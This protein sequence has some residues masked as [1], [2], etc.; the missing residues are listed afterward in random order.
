MVVEQAAAE[1][2]ERK[3]REMMVAHENLQLT[4]IN[5]IDNL[6]KLVPDKMVEEAYAHIYVKACNKILDPEYVS[7]HYD[8][9][10]LFGNMYVRKLGGMKYLKARCEATG[11]PFLN[12]L[13][14]VCDEAAKKVV[15]KK[16]EELVKAIS[17][18]DAE[19]IVRNAISDKDK[20]DLLD[21]IDDLGADQ[22]AELVK[23]KVVDVVRDEQIRERDEREQR[24]VLKNDLIS[25]D[26]LGDDGEDA[27]D[28]ADESTKKKGKKKKEDDDAE[29]DDLGDEDTDLGE[30]ESD[31]DKKSDKKKSKKKDKEDDES[32]DDDDKKK[33]DS[34]DDDKDSDNEDEDDDDKKSKKKKKDKEETKESLYPHSKWNPMTEQFEFI[35]TKNPGSF[36]YA[37]N[38]AIYQDMVKSLAATEG[39]SFTKDVSKRNS[40]LAMEAADSPLNISTFADYML[41]NQSG[42]R[43][44]ELAAVHDPSVIGDTKQRIDPDK[45][46]CESLVQY[47]LFETANTMRLI[48]VTKKMIAEQTNYLASTLDD[49]IIGR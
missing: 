16:K 37:L 33:D 27:L 20:K 41:D 42:Y 21:R 38:C 34:D 30:D 9:F 18:D 46:M 32:D 45:V 7:E 22:L 35:P 11:S 4:K 6:S 5:C 8:N 36:F 24:T 23:N 15:K 19:C 29:P 10:H 2:K 28:D 14:K 26:D 44:L 48:D 12:K 1:E 47:T 49:Q 17:C 13:Y 39:M 31:D 3:S 25:P 43:D 40:K